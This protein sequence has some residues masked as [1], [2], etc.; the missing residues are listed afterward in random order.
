MSKWRPIPT[1]C[2]YVIPDV[3]GQLSELK[4]IFNRILP[5]RK[6]EGIIDRVVML[7]DYID[8]RPDGPEVIDFLIG[9]KKKYKD[10]LILLTGNHELMLLDAIELMKN[11]HRYMLWMNN[12]G[13]QTLSRYLERIGEP[14]DNPYL[15]PRHRIKDIIPKEHIEFY[16]NL[17]PYYEIDNYVFVHGGYNIGVPIQ[18]HSKEELTWNRTLFEEIKTGKIEKIW[19]RTIVTGHNGSTGQP[20]ITNKFMMLDISIADKLL[21]VELN[22]MEAF[23]A[24]KKKKRLISVALSE[25]LIFKQSDS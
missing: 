17:A 23:I 15:F 6:S 22:S 21:V 8:R 3:H 20:F 2:L 24:A 1:G 18:K 12:G 7:G 4:L 11:S 10:Q 9:A 25:S 19:D 13:E 5:L 14:M 16:Q